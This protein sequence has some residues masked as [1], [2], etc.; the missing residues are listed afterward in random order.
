MLVFRGLAGA[1]AAVFWLVF[2]GRAGV[3]AERALTVAFTLELGVLVVLGA[4]LTVSGGNAGGGAGSGGG[5]ITGGAAT[6]AFA[7]DEATGCEVDSVGLLR[8]ITK[9]MLPKTS[10]SATP[11]PSRSGTRDAVGMLNSGSSVRPERLGPRPWL[12]SA[13]STP[14]CWVAFL[15]NSPESEGV[16]RG[17]EC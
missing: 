10:S 2:A 8:V 14:N 7:S 6:C 11:I 1:E 17:I 13:G 9:T 15:A 12:S 3:G 4:A 5:A 16:A